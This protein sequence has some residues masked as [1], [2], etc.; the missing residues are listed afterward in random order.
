ME[1]TRDCEYLNGT[2]TPAYLEHLPQTVKWERNS[3][4]LNTVDFLAAWLFT[5]TN[6]CIF[7]VE[8]MRKYKKQKKSHLDP[9]PG[10]PN[11]R[12]TDQYSRRWAV[13]ER[14]ELAKLHLPLPIAPHWSHYRLNHIPPSSHP[15]CGKNCLPQN[16]S[17]VPKRL[18]TTALYHLNNY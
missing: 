12:S 18:R 15:V 13:R 16:Q 4:S 2:E 11:P 10:V 9:T 1:G 6:A 7:I 14:A 8:R 3:L 17:L 5:L